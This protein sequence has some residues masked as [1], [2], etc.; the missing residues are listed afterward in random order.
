MRGRAGGIAEKGK[1]G[2][3]ALEGVLKR[4]IQGGLLCGR[5]GKE[6]AAAMRGARCEEEDGNEDTVVEEGIGM[7]GYPSPLFF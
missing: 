4:G 2:S 5:Q 1:G 6:G 3:E 7:E